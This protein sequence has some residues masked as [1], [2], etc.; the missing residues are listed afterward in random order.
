MKQLKEEIAS[1]ETTRD[2]YVKNKINESEKAIRRD[3]KNVNFEAQNRL[4]GL[5]CTSPGLYCLDYTFF[6]AS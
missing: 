3:L 4:S 2:D 5:F 6:Y 1:I